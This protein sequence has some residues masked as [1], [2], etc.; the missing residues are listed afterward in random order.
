GGGG[1]VRGRGRGPGGRGGGAPRPA[2]R[3]GGRVGGAPGPGPIPSGGG[4]R[5]A[6]TR[7]RTPPR[8]RS[9]VKWSPAEPAPITVAVSAAGP[10][11]KRLNAKIAV[12]SCWAI[13]IASAS[14]PAGS[15]TVALPVPTW[16]PAD[17]HE[18][19]GLAV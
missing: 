6:T 18:T 7:R 5:P 10:G 14:L 13:S 11:Q 8:R 15:G 9:C 19:G 4:G 1:A 2:P 3:G 17:G 16:R 12:P